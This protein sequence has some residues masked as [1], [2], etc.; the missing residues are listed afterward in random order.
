MKNPLVLISAVEIAGHT[1]CRVAFSGAILDV[2]I[3]HQVVT[4]RHTEGR[5]D[6][7]RTMA[8]TALALRRA[9][10]MTPLIY[11]HIIFV[12]CSSVKQAEI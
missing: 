1:G 5:T 9:V 3:K 12:Q 2:L 11:L 4:D 10:K 6:K 8:Y 7:H